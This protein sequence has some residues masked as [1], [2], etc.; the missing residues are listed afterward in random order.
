[1]HYSASRCLLIYLLLCHN[2]SH[3]AHFKFWP[4]GVVPTGIHTAGSAVITSH[5][6]RR[7]LLLPPLQPSSPTASLAARALLGLH[8]PIAPSRQTPTVK[9]TLT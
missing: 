6:T 2:P 9:T 3:G 4:V 7:R 5:H 1:M 8:G